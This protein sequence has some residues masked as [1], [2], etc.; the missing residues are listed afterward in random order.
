MRSRGVPRGSGRSYGPAGKVATPARGGQGLDSPAETRSQPTA[1]TSLDTLAPGTS[2]RLVA[3]GGERAFRCRLMEMGLLPGTL[4][5]LVRRADVGGVLELDVR[6][7]RLSVR[8]GEA[9]LLQVQP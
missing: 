5:R 4:V 8:H 6:G 9:R 1:V 7:A 2:A 3:I